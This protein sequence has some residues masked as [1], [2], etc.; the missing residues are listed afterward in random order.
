MCLT[1]MFLGAGAMFSTRYLSLLSLHLEIMNVSCWVMIQT[2]EP[3]VF[4][5]TLVVLKSC[6]IRC[7]M[8]LMAC[9]RTTSEMRGS[10]PQDRLRDS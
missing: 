7:L 3:I 5:T 10:L 8:R 6:V 1:F 4:L 2:L 9:D